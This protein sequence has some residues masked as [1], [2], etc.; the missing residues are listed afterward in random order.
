MSTTSTLISSARRQQ[1]RRSCRSSRT[2]PG[3]ASASTAQRTSKVTAGCSLSV[4]REAVQGGGEFRQSGDDQVGVGQLTWPELTRRD[5]DAE[6]ACGVCARDVSRRVA[7]GN[8]SLGGPIACT[9][10]REGEELY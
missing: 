9:L 1:A 2:T 6:T 4:L 5:A 8:G 10:A 3:S 7:H